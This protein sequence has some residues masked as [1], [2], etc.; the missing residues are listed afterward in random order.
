M[1]NFKKNLRMT[2]REITNLYELV[3]ILKEDKEEILTKIKN[4]IFNFKGNILEEEKWGK[5]ELAYRIKK[6]DS[7][8]Y[9]LWKITLPKKETLSLK[10]KLNLEENI[11]RYLLLKVKS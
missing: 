5:K 1:L 8:Y 9:F 3:F 6:Q 4:L 11:L 10:K 2:A 7:G